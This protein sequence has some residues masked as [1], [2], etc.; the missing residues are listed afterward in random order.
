VSVSASGH[1]R[2]DRRSLALHQAVAKKLRAHPEL[3]GIARENLN[4][5][6]EGAGRSRPYI[7]EWR[8]I[9]E[10]PL[11]EVLSLMEQDGERMTAL[12]QSSPFAGILEPA[13]RWAVYA[14]FEPVGDREAGE[15]GSSPDK[16][17]V[18][19]WSMS[20]GLRLLSQASKTSL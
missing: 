11:E 9:L 15:N 8:R 5:W 6:Y 1:L 20:F 13:E 3:I 14:R 7:D 16:S 18:R 2:I 17:R 4:R 12:R 19:S 10:L